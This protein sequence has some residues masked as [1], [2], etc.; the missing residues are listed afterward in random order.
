MGRKAKIKICN[1]CGHENA[2]ALDACVK[3]K[4]KR[5]APSWV[6]AKRPVNRQFGI[7]ITKTNPT[8]GDVEKRLTLSKWWPG[9][10][11]T[12]HIPSIGQWS[13]VERI[14]NDELGPILGWKTKK[15]LLESI[16]SKKISEVTTAGEVKKIVSEYPEFLKEIVTAIDPGK[17]GK[18]D[19]DKVTVLLGQLAG[20]VVS[21]NSGFR[22]AFLGVVKKL[23]Q[24]KQRALEELELLLDSW[25]LQQ[26]TFVAQQ[27]KGRLETIELFKKQILDERTYEINGDKSI[28]RILEKAMWLIDE[29][30]W[31]LQ[32]N[33]TLRTLIGNDLSK[34]DKKQFGKKRPDFVCGTVGEKL[35]IIELK[36]PSHTLKTDDL[37]QL[38]TYLSIAE[39]HLS[40]RSCEAYLIGNKK[41]S[42]LLR[43]LKHRSNNFKILTY[44]DLVGTAETRYRE[45]LKNIDV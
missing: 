45:Y 12:L 11:A 28:H 5:F 16:K 10:R 4:S 41:D 24:Q 29:R 44:A 18:E 15:Q 1:R 6:L 37:N 34:Q 3:C 42:D 43:R 30:Y 22:Q 2:Q 36:R 33:A 7:E 26:I 13:I 25:S 39:Q 9:G 20:A 40:Y 23:P 8:Y 38:E 14:I 27:V 31:L 17:L 35:I 32:S 19:M 21:A